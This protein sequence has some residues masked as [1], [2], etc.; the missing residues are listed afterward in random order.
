[1]PGLAL[2][3]PP[4]SHVTEWPTIFGDGLLAVNKVVL[5]MWLSVLI[6]GLLRWWVRTCRV[7]TRR[8]RGRWRG[9]W[10]CR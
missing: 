3:F 4:V 9:R 8:G 5:L 1:M 2:E 7:R 10:G 6:E